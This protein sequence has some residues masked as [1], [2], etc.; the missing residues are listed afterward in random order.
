MKRVLYEKYISTINDAI[1]LLIKLNV[2][3]V[4]EDRAHRYLQSAINSV[5]KNYG[6][7]TDD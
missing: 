4:A 5:N 7:N 1:T 2:N 6:A 3:N